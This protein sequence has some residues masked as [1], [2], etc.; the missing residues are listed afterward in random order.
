MSEL[1]VE[2]AQVTP[3]ERD[4]SLVWPASRAV[5][6]LDSGWPP[7]P[8]TPSA[9][10]APQLPKSERAKGRAGVDLRRQTPT[11]ARAFGVQRKSKAE[12]KTT[13]KRTQCLETLDLIGLHWARVRLPSLR[14][15]RPPTAHRR[16]S[17]RDR[18][19]RLELRRTGVWRGHVQ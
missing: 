9:P 4:G 7:A 18:G 11:N 10:G 3:Q 2:T 17:S 12:K 6:A 14:P 1:R 13:T 5:P 15:K 8:A 16:R 19:E